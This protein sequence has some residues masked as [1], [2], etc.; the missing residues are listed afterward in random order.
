MTDS[1][2]VTHSISIVIPAYNEEANIREVVLESLEVLRS[3][4]PRYE[5]LVMDDASQDS[6]GE[7]I[8]DLARQY[9]GEVRALHHQKNT[10]TNLSLVELFKAACCDLVF[11]LP[12][13]KQ[14]LPESLH[15]Y[16]E[17]MEKEQA[18]IV[19]GWRKNRADQSY[20][21]FFNWTFRFLLKILTGFNYHDAAAS[22][23]YKKSVL[24]QIEMESRGRLLQAEIAAK[25]S[26]LGYRVREVEVDHHPR[27]AGKQTG[28][29]PKTA[30]LSLMDL[31]RVGPKIRALALAKKRV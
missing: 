12:A 14:I 4:T 23:L 17:R 20:R 31:L 19:M 16:L 28:I 24:D 1:L 2:K 7:I 27:I 25:A 6:T 15:R 3:L 18:D 13:D 8:E 22:D 30:Y 29:K 26:A 10:G 11:F 5:I 9:P 21:A